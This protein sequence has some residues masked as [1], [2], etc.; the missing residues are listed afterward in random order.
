MEQNGPEALLW[1]LNKK[2][3]AIWWYDD[4]CQFWIW[5][6]F[7]T[8]SIWT[9]D[10]EIYLRQVSVIWVINNGRYMTDKIPMGRTGKLDEVRGPAWELLPKNP[11]WK[12]TGNTVGHI[13]NM[14]KSSQGQRSICENRWKC[15]PK[16]MCLGAACLLTSGLCDLCTSVTCACAHVHVQTNNVCTDCSVSSTSICTSTFTFAFTSAGTQQRAM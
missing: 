10:M 6:H 15:A 5:L 7:N 9:L 16:L 2:F 4:R 11:R 1:Y 14:Y 3:M 8:K 13:M 12:D